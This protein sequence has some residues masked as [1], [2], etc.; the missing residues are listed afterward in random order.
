MT[1]LNLYTSNNFVIECQINW[2]S[3]LEKL[4]WNET[5][6][7]LAEV[8]KR[9]YTENELHSNEYLMVFESCHLQQEQDAIAVIRGLSDMLD[10]SCCDCLEDFVANDWT[11]YATDLLGNRLQDISTSEHAALI[12]QMAV[13]FSDPNDNEH[14]GQFEL[15]LGTINT[16]IS[17]W[18]EAIWTARALGQIVEEKYQSVPDFPVPELYFQ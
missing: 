2:G 8:V 14:L 3:E 13:S 16:D 4:S 17:G 5:L 1:Q 10:D 15:L 9:I 11:E 6:L 18:D 7:L 12:K